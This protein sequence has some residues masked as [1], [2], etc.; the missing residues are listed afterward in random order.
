ML[1]VPAV[2]F[3]FSPPQKSPFFLLADI[4]C[5]LTFAASKLTYL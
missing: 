4:L 2:S 3:K 5:P 1:S